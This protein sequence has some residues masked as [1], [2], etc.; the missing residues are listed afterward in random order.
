MKRWTF[1]KSTLIALSICAT[2]SVAL[3]SEEL[4]GE[5]ILVQIIERGRAFENAYL[6][7]FSRREAKVEVL[8]G[9]GGDPKMTREI[10][11]DVWD[12]HG[13]PPINEVRECKIDSEPVELAECVEKRQLDPVYRLFGA[14]SAEHYR[15][16]YR[17]LSTWKGQASHKIGVIPL[18]E[19]M[20]HLK[21][22]VFFHD[23]T[24]RVVG[25]N[26]TLGDYPFGLKD[27]SIQLSFAEQEGKPVIESG[28]TSVHVYVPL[29][30]N[31][32]TH[33]RFTASMQRLLVERHTAMTGT[34]TR[35][36]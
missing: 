14:K 34:E 4:S 21:G 17:G 23:E 30:I 6:G 9:D 22:D 36:Q 29:L 31:E 5:E 26:V 27:L 2:S 25:M 16:E 18:E 15:M 8:G 28:D 10:V 33:T 24:L 11:V 32:R 1:L 13:E 35:A 7:S 3:G 20:R 12:Y 19:T